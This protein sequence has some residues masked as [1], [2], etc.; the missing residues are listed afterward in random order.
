MNKIKDYLKD[1]SFLKYIFYSIYIIITISILFILLNNP[2]VKN[3]FRTIENK[4]FD[5]RQNIIAAHKKVNPNIAIITVDNESYEYLLEKYGEWPISRKI[6]ADIATYLLKQNVA[7][8]SYDLM[9]VKSLKSSENADEILANTIKNNQN[10]FTSINFDNQSFDLR[11]PTTLP[12]QLKADVINESN[13]NL[14]NGDYEFLNCRTIIDKI[15]YTTKNIGH[16][17]ILRDEDGIARTIPPFVLYQNGT[18]E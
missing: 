14:K 13:I 2:S 4:T 8:I 11:K 18:P 15:L 9:F 3:I 17:N 12:E 5:I 6:Y 10:I 1:K 7:T 16:V